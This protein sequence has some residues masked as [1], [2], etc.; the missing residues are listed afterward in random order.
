[1]GKVKPLDALPPRRFGASGVDWEQVCT[2]VAEQDGLWCE[3]GSFSPSVA[4]HIRKGKYP[5]VDPAR[6]EVTTQKDESAPGKSRL[7]MRL[8]P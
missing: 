6:F 8:R 5:S 2:E 4:V 3:V 7:Y 1:M